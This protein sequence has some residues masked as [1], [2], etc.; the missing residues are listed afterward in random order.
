MSAMTCGAT[1][2][3]NVLQIGQRRSPYSVIVTLA[4]AFPIVPALSGRSANSALTS[5]TPLRLARSGRP[6]ELPL[7]SC[8][9][10]TSAITSRTAEPPAMSMRLTRA[11][12]R[13]CS[14][15]A[16][17]LRAFPIAA[18]Y[19]SRPPAPPASRS[20]NERRSRRLTRR[21]AGLEARR[22]ALLDAAEMPDRERQR[23]RR[24]EQADDEVAD[25]VQVEVRDEVPD[26]AV[27][28]QLVGEHRH[29]LDRAD[30]QRHGHR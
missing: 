6:P 3:S 11:R 16:R 19:P 28:T 15:R 14:R 17:V 8:W 29:E 27:Q 26:A 24:H 23:P 22:P 9:T 12:R 10:T 5:L 21:A 25:D 18:M 4:L 13:S 1:S 2:L 7:V 30:D 20:R